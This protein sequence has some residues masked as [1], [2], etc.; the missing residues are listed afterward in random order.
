MA[1]YRRQKKKTLI[2]EYTSNLGSA[3]DRNRVAKAEK[4]KL[5]EA[6]RVNKIT[7]QF[8]ANMSHELRTPLNSIIGFSAML[9]EADKHKNLDPKEYGGI[10]NQSAE[11][12]LSIINEILDIS[13]IQSDQQT[14]SM[15]DTQIDAL[16]DD[17]LTMLKNQIADKDIA[18]V[19]TIEPDIPEMRLDPAKM[20]QIF[21]NIITNAIKFTPKGGHVTIFGHLL[22]EKTVQISIAD[23]GVGMDAEEIGLALTPFGQVVGDLSRDFQGTGL[24]LPIAKSLVELHGGIL[25]V[26]SEKGV[27]SIFDIILPIKHVKKTVTHTNTNQP[28]AA[29]GNIVSQT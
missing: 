8:I 28:D 15:E 7:S 9:R 20:L 22:N 16:L 13:R 29:P 25:E 5:A 21:T 4:A 14:L 1:G 19:C 3:L 2:S 10:I 6:E 23:N 12:L 24:G 17:C 27:G 26:N 18:M 11:Q